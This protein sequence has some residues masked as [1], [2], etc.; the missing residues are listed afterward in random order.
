M[1]FDIGELDFQAS[2]EGLSYIPQT[3]NAIKTKLQKVNSSLTTRLAVEA[4]AITN[5]W[6]RSA[7]LYS[8]K[9]KTLWNAAVLEYATNTKFDLYDATS[10][11]WG[12]SHTIH[13][14]S[15]K[16]AEFNIDIAA[17]QFERGKST[18]NK[19]KIDRDS[20]TGTTHWN[21]NVEKEVYFVENDGK[22]GATERAKYHWR[23]KQ[24]RAYRETVFVL[25]KIDKT[26][27]I[28]TKGFFATIHN[29]P[30]QSMLK[31]SDLNQKARVS[32]GM[33]KN[34]SILRLEERGGSRNHSNSSDLVFRSAG[35]L[36]SFDNSKTYY[37]VPVT[38]YTPIF[39]EMTNWSLHQLK[40]LMASS[41]IDELKIEV[42]GVRVSKGD[43]TTIKTFKNW[44]NIEDHI[45]AV[46]NKTNT[47]ICMATVLEKLDN[48]RVLDY[49]KGVALKGITNTKSP[50]AEMLKRLQLLPKHTGT[51]SV[52]TLMK[53]F[54]IAPM[55]DVVDLAD[56]YNTALS[57]FK[58]RYPLIEK[59]GHYAKEDDLCEYINLVDSVKGV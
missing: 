57:L 13:V 6:E 22:V 40:H 24:D 23:N 25:N 41:T 8:K 28:D 26:K 31:A 59:F 58:A 37:Y 30:A 35:T 12:S 17:F 50:A 51:H 36:D 55:V 33:G 18:A 48:S 11:R 34:V 7:F 56:K 3:I 39:S 9:T 47:E 5:E 43:L 52:N 1:H 42:Y 38:G 27:P 14:T 15:T 16:L 46:L 19:L 2:R 10:S 45:K 4:D 32:G 49:N 53:A 44:I 20:S 29:P 54:K 21:I